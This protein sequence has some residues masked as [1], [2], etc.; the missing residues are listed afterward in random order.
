[1][2]DSRSFPCSFYITRRHGGYFFS[3]AVLCDM[4]VLD[5]EETAPKIFPD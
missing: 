2:T 1:M 3:A 4:N 5:I